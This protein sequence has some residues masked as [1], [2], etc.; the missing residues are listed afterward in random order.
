MIHPFG[1]VT[2]ATTEQLLIQK[3]KEREFKHMLRLQRQ[4]MHSQTLAGE[5]PLARMKAYT[6]ISF[7][8][9]PIEVDRSGLIRQINL[10]GESRNK[11]ESFRSKSDARLNAKRV[12]PSI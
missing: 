1:R 8:K 9:G 3:E 2:N 5:E 10:I 12:L 11:S 4:I 6:N 7:A